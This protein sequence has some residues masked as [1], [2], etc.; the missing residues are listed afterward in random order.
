MTRR[1]TTTLYERMRARPEDRSILQWLAIVAMLVVLGV[2]VYTGAGCAEPVETVAV[3]VDESG[4]VQC[5]ALFWNDGYGWVRCETIDRP[6]RVEVARQNGQVIVYRGR[7]L[8]TSTPTLVDPNLSQARQA[9]HV[10][11]DL[12]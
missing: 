9:Q 4:D 8:G 11:K 1:P 10:G 3:L 12:P 2:L 5:V 7:R 6:L